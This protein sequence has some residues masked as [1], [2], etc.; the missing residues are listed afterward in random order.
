M[1]TVKLLV[2]LVED[3]QILAYALV[4]LGLIF[5]GEV[6]VIS[7]GILAHLGALNF[8]F[9]LLFILAGGLTKTFLCYYAGELIHDRWHKARLLKF[10]ESRLHRVMPRFRQ[11]PF[12][13]IFVSKFITGTNYIVAIFSGFSKINY[14]KYL[15]AEISATLVWAPLLLCLGYFFSYTA[16]HIS[17]EISRFSLI[18]IVLIVAFVV[19][20]RFIA[21]VY[22]VLEEYYNEANGKN[23]H[24]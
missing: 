8:Y 13:S 18:V 3:H 5:E 1:H 10:I 16:L 6:V 20:D 15:I 12:W 24:S 19:F 2:S 11:K 17:K 7:T 21:W 14:K 23:N 22:E 4:F 9:A